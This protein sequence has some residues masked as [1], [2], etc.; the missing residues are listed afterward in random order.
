MKQNLIMDIVQS[1]LP[2][3]NNAQIQRFRTIYDKICE[4]KHTLGQY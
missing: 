1:M 4:I 2:Y 3:L